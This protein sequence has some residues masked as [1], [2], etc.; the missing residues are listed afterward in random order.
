MIKLMFHL[1]AYWKEILL[2]IALLFVQAMCDLSLPNYMSNIINIGIQQGGIS[3]SYPKALDKKGYELLTLFMKKEDKIVFQNAYRI[4]HSEEEK[5]ARQ[6]PLLKVEPI[7]VKKEHVDEKALNTA[8]SNAVVGMVQYASSMKGNEKVPSNGEASFSLDAIYEM[9]PMLQL[10]KDE[11]ATF[12]ENQ[13]NEDTSLLKQSSKSMIQ[14]FYQELGVNLDQVRQNYIMVTGVKMLGLAFVIAL[15]AVLVSFVT[16]LIGAKFGRDVRNEV[17]DKVGSFSTVEMK[18]FTTASLITRT[19]ND[20]TQVQ[21]GLVMT[22]RMLFR[23]PVTGVGGIIMALGKSSSMSWIIALAVLVLIGLL[24]LVFS[25][26]MP[27]FK[28]MQKLVDE[29]N[30]VARENLNGM[31]V[32]RAFATQKFEQK[33]FDKANKNITKTNLFISRVMAF[34]S[35]IMTLVMNGVVILIVWVGANQIQNSSVQVGDMMAYIQYAMQIIMSFL[36][37]AMMFIMIPRSS[38]SCNR[39]LEILETEPEIKDPENPKEFLPEKRGYV[40]FRNVNFRYADAEEDVLH[41]ISFVAEPGKTTAFI[42]STGSGKSTLINLIPRFF[43]VTGGKVLVNG[44]DVKEVKKKDLCEVIGYIP[45]KGVLL[46]GT[47]ASNLR[48][49]KENATKKELEEAASVAQALSFIEAKEDGFSSHIAQGGSNVSGGQKQ[50]LSIARALVKK[51]D[52]YIFDDSFSA[53]DFKTD[54]KLRAELKEYTKGS[55]VLIVAQRISTIMNA[56]QIVVIDR[57][58]VVGIGTHEELLKNCKTYYEIAS[59]QLTKEELA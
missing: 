16:S 49:G 26:A 19:T 53:L 24:G 7:Y 48:Y 4:A 40:E 51:P 13:K 3:E 31:L 9:L 47:I 25:I 41:H 57:G 2:V 59:S 52:V 28:K 34:M 38:V 37:L 36:M 15:T 27:K 35:P 45:Q 39:I 14:L 30:L 5:L 44:V 11:I 54:A 58:E 12:L 17:F 55:T 29:L 22:L 33:R 6:Y 32:I 42:G 50:R 10:K 56:E 21:M 20:I 18:K 23:A 1:K 43:D 8:F 46:S